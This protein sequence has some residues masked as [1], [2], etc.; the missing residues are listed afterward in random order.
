MRLLFVIAILMT[1]GQFAFAGHQID[2]FATR[3]MT[4]NGSEYAVKSN[5]AEFGEN[6]GLQSPVDGD[7]VLIL[8][9]VDSEHHPIGSFSPPKAWVS[10]T[11]IN[12]GSTITSRE[13]SFQRTEMRILR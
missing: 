11:S 1:F 3:A 6:I 8:N 5:D 4:C 10:G 12:A 9:R 13:M 2:H 7:E